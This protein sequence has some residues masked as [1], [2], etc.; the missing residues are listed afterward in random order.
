[1]PDYGE[2][3]S[4]GDSYNVPRSRQAFFSTKVLLPGTRVLWRDSIA[5]KKVM[6]DGKHGDFEPAGD[7]EFLEDG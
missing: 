7:S 3:N 5:T 2:I 4:R 1:M 6:L